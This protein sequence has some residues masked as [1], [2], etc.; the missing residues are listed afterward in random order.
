MGRAWAQAQ[1]LGSG[2][3]I[4]KTQ[5]LS[6]WVRVKP[7]PERSPTYLVTSSSLKEPEPEVWNPSLTRTQKNQARPISTEEGL[8]NFL[9]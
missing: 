1:I 9:F 6:P 3:L 4:N 7:K 5:S 2:F 8:L